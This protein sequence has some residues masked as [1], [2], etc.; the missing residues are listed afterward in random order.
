MKKM[1]LK[2]FGR[3]A[4]MVLPLFLLI[5]LFMFSATQSSAQYLSG[6]LAQDL[7][8]KHMSELKPVLASFTPDQMNPQLKQKAEVNNFR[9]LYGT[10]LVGLLADG[11]TV[12]GAIDRAEEVFLSPPAGK[13]AIKQS[14]YDAVKQE[15]EL[16]LTD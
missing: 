8:V 1:N 11:Q 2:F 4:K 7:I 6:D 15:Y 3:K 14:V 5:G 16:I 12:S 9:H 10:A 13:P